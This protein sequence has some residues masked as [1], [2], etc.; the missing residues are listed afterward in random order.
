M[1]E[2]SRGLGLAARFVSGC[3]SDADIPDAATPV[4]DAGATHAWCAV[5]VSGAGRMEFD[6]TNGLIAGRNLIRVAV[7]RTP[8][9]SVP[10][11][12]SWSGAPVS[13]LGLDVD[14]EVAVEAVAQ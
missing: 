4:V 12:G 14:A 7:A 3:L 10:I 5:Y 2:A 13:F 1:T 11:A 6:P 9:Q 8:E